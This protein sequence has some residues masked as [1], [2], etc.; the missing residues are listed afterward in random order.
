MLRSP[1]M[2]SS[3]RP[4]WHTPSWLWS[5]RVAARRR[6]GRPRRRKTRLAHDQRGSPRGAWPGPRPTWKPRGRNS[7]S[8]PTAEAALKQARDAAKA[9]DSGTVI[10]QVE[11]RRRA[12]QGRHGAV[13]LS[14]HRAALPGRGPG[15]FRAARLAAALL[16]D[17]ALG[18]ALTAHLLRDR[19]STA[20]RF[21]PGPCHAVT[22][23]GL[24][25]LV[26]DPQ[27]VL[28]GIDF[29]KFFPQTG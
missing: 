26:P 25:E 19:R 2:K 4:S 14:L 20:G 1:S 6:P 13:V 27:L 3:S 28:V 17:L 11:I 16:H 29:R 9:G 22:A 12:G 10:Q 23:S 5:W 15:S 7:R 21:P 8:G 18:G 24:G